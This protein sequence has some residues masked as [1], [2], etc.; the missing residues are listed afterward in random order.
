M[1]LFLKYSIIRGGQNNLLGQNSILTGDLIE[2]QE[3]MIIPVDGLLIEG[4]EILVD[5]SSLTGETN[6][7]KKKSLKKCIEER[8]LIIDQFGKSS[9][10]IVSSPILLSGTKV[11]NR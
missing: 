11:I 9:G 6:P 1:L 2:I 8:N 10:N 4:L 3:G 7:S 5:E